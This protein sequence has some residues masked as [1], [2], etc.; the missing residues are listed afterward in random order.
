MTKNM[1]KILNEKEKKM[2]AKKNDLKKK[3]Y[4]IQKHN[5]NSCRKEE[6]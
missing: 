6:D 1:T 4:L 5:M 3:I 2:V